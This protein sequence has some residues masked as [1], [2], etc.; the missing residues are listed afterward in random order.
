M[1]V[2]F[3][4]IETLFKT[5]IPIL[6]GKGKNVYTRMIEIYNINEIVSIFILN[7]MI[8]NVNSKYHP[9]TMNETFRETINTA[10]TMKWN[11]YSQFKY[12]N[13][14]DNDDLSIQ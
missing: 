3:F 9:L 13:N 7:N 14:N 10:T 1:D 6:S 12:K 11:S 8:M 5:V 4:L 2:S